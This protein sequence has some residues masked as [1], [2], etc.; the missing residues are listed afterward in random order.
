MQIITVSKGSHSYGDNFARTLAS[1][2]D[3]ECIGRDEILEEATRQKIPIGKLE[4]A[5]IKPHIFSEE[6][7][8]ELEHFKA[9][10]TSL[11]C[12][13]ALNHNIIYHGRTGHLLL[14]GIEHILK[15]RV[16]AD[17][18]S[19]IDFV[20]QKLDLT[21]EKAKQYI[22]QL[23]Q[24]RK[25]WVKQFYNVDWDTS[26]FYDIVVNLS[27]LNVEN[28]ATAV[29]AMAQLPEFQTTPANTKSLQNLYL[30]SS[31][32]LL[33]AM[34]KRTSHL[35]IKVRSTDNVVY[36]TYLPQQVKDAKLITEVL[37]ELEDAKEIICTEAETNI[38]W[39]QEAFKPDDSSYKD[40]LNLACMWDAA[41]ELI[42]LTPSEVSEQLTSYYEKNEIKTETWQE[43]G[44]IDDD[45]ETAETESKG[46]SKIYEKLINDGVAGGKKIVQGSQK[47]LLNTID[48]GIPYRLIILDNIFALKGH[49]T[50]IR[51]QREWSN[52]ISDNLKV[53]VVSL[54]ELRAKYSFGIKEGI[55]MTLSALIVII[56]V[57]LIFQF[58]DEI[59]SF[60]T[61]EEL[62]W[63]I[64][65]SMCVFV[66]V[67][68]FAYLYSTVT[69]LFLRIIKFE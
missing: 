49:A 37:A 16:I 12:K 11:L 27:H 59:L 57:Y 56:I 23:D 1:K 30:S 53:P 50:Q 61:K 17:L 24:D 46:I 47:T 35:N 54:D 18:E 42:Q 69:K 51:M 33:L 5:I 3:Y 9:L 19:R 66:F 64:L 58:N 52:F 41:V 13:K 40:V 7:A 25:K 67:P 62:T 26:S 29:C 21:R 6:L 8:L 43:A 22:E 34:D 65:A 36:V 32:R 63:K 10:A 48:R 45:V 20:M 15:I 55:Q 14:P 44:I 39:I 60:L 2:L 38:L 4:T 31:A 28:A 68:V